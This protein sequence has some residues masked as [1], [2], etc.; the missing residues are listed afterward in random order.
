MQVVRSNTPG[1]YT[2]AGQAE[3]P[4]RTPLT[5]IAVRYLHLDQQPEKNT[6]PTY[7]ILAY[8]T[9]L[10]MNGQWQTNLNL[11]QVAS[12]GQYQES[13][14]REQQHLNLNL[15]PDEAVAFLATLA[16]VDSL[17]KIEQMLANQ[18]LQLPKQQLRTTLEG[19]RFAQ[20]N[21]TLEVALP[22]GETTPAIPALDDRND[23]WGERYLI[24]K[25]PQNPT[26]LTRP[27]NR[28]TNAPPRTVE[29]LQ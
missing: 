25:E 22:V 16:P 5:I 19:D 4:D 27:E 6:N 18:G 24:P 11:W 8:Q 7:S 26:R 21:Q 28:Q 29:F 14:Q 17:P 2:I 15:K 10:V 12:N 23:G 20:L 13:W 9:T 1:Q 3:L